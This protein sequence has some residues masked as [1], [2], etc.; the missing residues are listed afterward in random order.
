MFLISINL[1]HG[2]IACSSGTCF[3]PCLMNQWS[4]FVSFKFVEELFMH[5]FVLYDFSQKIQLCYFC[6][7]N[8]A[9]SIVLVEPRFF[10]PFGFCTH[11]EGL[12]FSIEQLMV[13]LMSESIHAPLHPLA[14]QHT[15]H[16]EHSVKDSRVEVWSNAW[17]YRA[18]HIYANDQ[19][20]SNTLW[21]NVYQVISCWNISK[22]CLFQKLC[23]DHL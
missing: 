8:I 6:D 17:P 12:W 20:T 22:T 2:L 21:R 14:T 19:S 9:T 18:S 1:F 5:F 16:W 15:P 7:G 4:V 13:V 11:M 23:S 10:L 3:V